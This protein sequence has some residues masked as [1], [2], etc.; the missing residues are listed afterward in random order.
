MGI[1]GMIA[2]TKEKFKQQTLEAE[3][4]VMQ[5]E[6][7]SLQMLH[8]ERIFHEQ[9]ASVHQQVEAEKAK[10]VAAREKAPKVGL[11]KFA[12]GLKKGVVKLKEERAKFRAENPD[13]GKPRGVF[14]P[15]PNNIQ[16]TAASTVGKK[17]KKA[18]LEQP[19]NST[20]FGNGLNNEVN[21][22]GK[23]NF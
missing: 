12:D 2:R 4:A 13:F 21:L 14:A 18:K 1:L 11:A 10:L 5:K 9:R 8:K 16:P 20:G 22:F 15:L 23:G 19:R 7:A 6:A 17:Q 3:R